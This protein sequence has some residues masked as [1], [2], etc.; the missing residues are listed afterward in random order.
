[1]GI[2]KP[3]GAAVLSIIAIVVSGLSGV[4]SL[5]SW[6]TSQ[7]ALANQSPYINIEA[8]V[9]RL[10][11]DGKFTP[12]LPLIRSFVSGPPQKARIVSMADIR[13]DHD[14]LQLTFHNGGGR[15]IKIGQVGI[16]GGN[17]TV[18]ND[19]DIPAAS[20]SCG[21]RSISALGCSGSVP[22]TVNRQDQSVLYYPLFVAAD[23]LVGANAGQDEELRL[24][25][26]SYDPTSQGNKPQ[27]A[28]IKI[29][30]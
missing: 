2:P 13:N 25:Y 15:E 27:D 8:E 18:F 4:G 22:F 3:S 26:G 5:L 7:R 12:I 14:W 19:S 21:Y 10:T 11:S 9:G 30:A 1:M 16:V 23:F 24:Q 17:D 6:H 29:T 20:V 28:D